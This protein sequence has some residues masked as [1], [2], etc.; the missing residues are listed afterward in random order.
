MADG[1]RGVA[2][3]EDDGDGCIEGGENKSYDQD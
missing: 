3:T 2:A 1:A